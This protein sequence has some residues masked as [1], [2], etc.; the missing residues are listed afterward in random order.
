M[1]VD[2]RRIEELD[3]FEVTLEGVTQD[4]KIIKQLQKRLSSKGYEFKLTTCEGVYNAIGRYYLLK[5][6]DVEIM[7]FQHTYYVNLNNG[8]FVC[9][10]S[11][12]TLEKLLEELDK[13]YL[14]GS[15]VNSVASA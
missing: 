11:L 6:K 12:E 3:K 9:F 13:P 5:K 14:W 7:E 8:K 4:E 10:V 1:A 2:F 15:I